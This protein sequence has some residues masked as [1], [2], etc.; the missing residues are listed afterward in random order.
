[1][2]DDPGAPETV[3]ARI[4]GPKAGADR[5]AEEIELILSTLDEA[6]TSAEMITSTIDTDLWV[7]TLAPSNNPAGGFT[8]EAAQSQSN[9][10][11]VKGE[12]ERL[13]AFLETVLWKER[14]FGARLFR[15]LEIGRL[16]VCRVE[17][18][19]IGSDLMSADAETEMEAFYA[20]QDTIDATARYLGHLRERMRNEL[21]WV[22]RS[23][24][25]LAVAEESS[26]KLFGERMRRVGNKALKTQMKAARTSRGQAHPDFF[27][28]FFTRI[29]QRMET[30]YYACRKA[31]NTDDF[32]AGAVF[33]VSSSDG[34]SSEV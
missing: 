10:D 20:L 21:R 34:M 4:D 14:F 17:H 9:M 19:R 5:R 8:A 28:F 27:F 33:V 31:A 30:H 15:D 32:Q 22:G 18:E 23:G 24:E 11:A 25:L 13:C 1:M 7:R 2:S 26:E 6:A 29:R 3:Y 16:R 12:N